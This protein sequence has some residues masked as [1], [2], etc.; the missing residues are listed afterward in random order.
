MPDRQNANCRIL[1]SGRAMKQMCADLIDRMNKEVI[2]I[3]GLGFLPW[4]QRL[5]KLA[6]RHSRRLECPA[7][8]LGGF[9]YDR[10]V[11]V[12]VIIIC[13]DIN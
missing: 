2:I 9:D 3:G 5:R 8:L 1:G 6:R 11:A 4:L 12:T 13:L 10:L 7:H